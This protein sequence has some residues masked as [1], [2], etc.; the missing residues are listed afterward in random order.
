MEVLFRG[1]VENLRSPYPIGS[2]VNEDRFPPVVDAFDNRFE[3]SGERVNDARRSSLDARDI[4]LIS[5]DE[6][7]YASMAVGDVYDRRE[8]GVPIGLCETD[9]ASLP[10]DDTLLTDPD[11]YRWS[12]GGGTLG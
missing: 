6:R 4:R 8:T 10:G 11:E 5:R 1:D 7:E 3:S 12:S 9:G 2:N